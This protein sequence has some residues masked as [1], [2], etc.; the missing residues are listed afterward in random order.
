MSEEVVTKTLAIESATRH[1]APRKRT[2]RFGVL[3]VWRSTRERVEALFVLLT[4]IGL[5]AGAILERSGAGRAVTLPVHGATYLFGAYF[6][7]L[8][9]IRA[10]R[11]VTVEVDMLMVLAALGAAYV[12]AWTEGATLLFLFSLSNVLQNY[13]MGRTHQAI[14]AL[15][16]LRPDTVRLRRNGEIVEASLEDVTTDDQFVLRPGDR[17]PLDGRIVTGT[18]YFDESSVTGESLPVGKTMGDAVL[19]G[20]LNQ[21][22]AFDVQVTR[23]ASES[24]L[25][26][27]IAMVEDARERKAAMESFLDR[28]EK[29]YAVG[30]IV[31]VA[32]YVAGMSLMTT[33]AFR[34]VFYRAMV[35]LTVA[36]PCALVISVPATV[37]SAIAGGARGGVLFKGGGYVEALYGVRTVAFDKT[38]TLTFGRPEVADI[39]PADGVRSEYLL[40][41]AAR[42][43][44]HS[45]HPIARAIVRY[46]GE[47]G[48][49][50]KE[51]EGFAE[52]IGSGVTAE[53][54]GK[55]TLIGSPRMMEN[56]GLPLD[57]AMTDR[58]EELRRHGRKTVL[59]VYHA[60]S[61]L[62]TISVMDRER[63]DAAEQIRL[64]R[65][66]GMRRIVMLTGDDETTARAMADRLGIDEMHAGLMPED[67]VSRIE[68]LQDH[69]GPVA[70]V[71]D[72]VNDAPALAR[73][74]VGI[75][76]GAAGTDAA[77]ESA[78]VVL[79]ADDL[80]A[81]VRAVRMSRRARRVITQNVVFAM[82]VVVTL[83]TLTLTIG[84]PLPLGVLG[85]EGSTIIVVLNGLR[86]LRKPV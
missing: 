47:A 78:D 54:S 5:I 51:P 57:A 85:H 72:G 49:H 44:I 66:A 45:Q 48:I 52:S 82:G 42:A 69:Y 70:M 12:D 46:A 59:Q 74:R 1:A 65:A 76:M 37:L 30:V 56:R 28:A 64:L 21:S 67:K 6:A 22:G 9:I 25:S 19:A 60:G 24:T 81:L 8:E 31:L 77:L 55:E 26:R 10:V 11:E 41:V 16:S 20:T 35:L 75:A 61:W 53:W 86:L 13:A 62:G 14:S 15:L 71:G 18:G 40:A 83:A 80:G 84:I 2:P 50:P 3:R 43:E 23:P 63:P 73:A 36:S 27:I 7:T 79:M 58:I 38:G 32:L 34:V 68:A 29:Y 4:L 33:I 39:L 17:V